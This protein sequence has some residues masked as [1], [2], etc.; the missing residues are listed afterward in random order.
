MIRHCVMLRLRDDHDRV[1]LNDVI[2]QL[3]KL[4][5]QLDNCGGFC[6]GPNRDYEDKSP[7]YPFGFTIDFASAQALSVYA[8]DPRHQ[9]LGARLVSFCDGGC[10]G[11]TVYDLEIADPVTR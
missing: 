6:A 9:M 2:A 3:Q 10:D 8:N 1:A 5:G 4:T 11:I 7:D